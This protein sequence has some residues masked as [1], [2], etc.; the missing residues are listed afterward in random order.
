MDD[1]R[2]S[3]TR[4]LEI[5]VHTGFG[6]PAR[7]GTL[8]GSALVVALAGI[9]TQPHESLEQALSGV[10]PEAVDAE[11]S[12]ILAW[13]DATFD[14]WVAQY[15]IDSEIQNSLQ[16]MK[17][18]AAA[19]ACEEKRFFTPGAHA[20]HRLL[21]TLHAGFQGWSGDLGK[22][23]RPALE[24]VDEAI[25]RCLQDFPSEPAVDHTLH[26]LE[27]K[28]GA[29]R[30][31]L[32]RLDEG[33]V[34]REQLAAG[35][36]LTRRI[37]GQTLAQILGEHEVPSTLAALLGG[38]WF[39]AASDVIQNTGVGSEL[40][41]RYVAVTASLVDPLI[42]PSARDSRADPAS[43]APNQL[44]EEIKAILQQVGFTDDRAQSAAST[45][46]YLLLR[47]ASGQDTGPRESV[48]LG[49]QP[50]SVWRAI[51]AEQLSEK[52]IES[53][54][55][56][57]IQQP[58]GFRPLRLA[59]TL[60][61][62]TYLIFMDFTG[63]SALRL[64]ADEFINLL[65]SGEAQKLDS[66]QTFSRALVESVE[67]NTAVRAQQAAEKAAA[68]T[69]LAEEAAQQAA[70]RAQK[71][72]EAAQRL[73]GAETRSSE[74]PQTLGSADTQAG[75]QTPSAERPFDRKT[76]LQLRIP[77]G[78]WLGFH[79]RE[80]PIMAKVAVR[81]LENDSY[82][83]SNRDGIKLR[84]LTVPQL[85]TLIERDMVDILEHKTSFKQTLATASGSERLGQLQ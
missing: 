64:S 1:E 76:V 40:W 37:I 51:T 21:D 35:G 84:E 6:N 48:A 63:A 20:L 4:S 56:Y 49:G 27:Q 38:D 70:Q 55:W 8:S 9:T 74:M 69:A 23:A 29:H 61:E 81:D 58:E 65:H 54:E 34:E 78:T 80:P 25:Q 33:L 79:D 53:G 19:F 52:G 16:A 43:L 24:A 5:D 83:F 14:N 47:Q 22:T 10:S 62:N 28:I 73:C 3:L 13:V 67:K 44:P 71:R 12:A 42:D 36:T 46:E 66:H 75:N 68:E 2:L 72:N 57:R 82:I 17:P 77:I 59:G 7:N 39:E 11:A 32:E 15:P 26:L 41:Q 30:E 85:V 60:A 45:V 18:L 50:A 31:Q